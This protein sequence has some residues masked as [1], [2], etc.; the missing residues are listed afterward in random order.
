MQMSTEKLVQLIAQRLYD[1]KGFNIMAIDVREISSITDY[2][3]IAEG[4]IERHAMALS[5]EIQDCLRE[6]GQKPFRVEGQEVGD[7]V[8]MDYLDIMVHLFIPE[9]REKYQLEKLW[10][11][12]KIVD[13]HI[14]TENSKSN[15]I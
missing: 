10:S 14:Q 9:M 12:G 2:F 7:W 3:I 13:L 8:V 11:E 4:N 6:Y 5:N 15:V 1:K